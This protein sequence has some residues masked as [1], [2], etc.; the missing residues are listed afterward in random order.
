MWSYYLQ[1][2]E[3]IFPYL[4]EVIASGEI[5]EQSFGLNTLVLFLSPMNTYVKY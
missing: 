1:N 2:N 4:K 5:G 3:Q